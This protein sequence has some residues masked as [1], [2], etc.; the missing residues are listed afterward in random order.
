M[1]KRDA[2]KIIANQA[3]EIAGLK[4]QIAA[5]QTP[6]PAPVVAKPAPA[7]A[8]APKKPKVLFKKSV[9]AKAKEEPKEE[10]E[11]EIAAA[12]GYRRGPLAALTPEQLAEQYGSAGYDDLVTPIDDHDRNW[13]ATVAKLMAKGG[14]QYE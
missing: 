4:A 2:E 8:P 3:K 13:K 1:R 9:P 10:P 12:N 5:L 11:P 14:Y 6:A 7:P